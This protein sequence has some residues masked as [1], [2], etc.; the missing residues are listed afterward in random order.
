MLIGSVGYGL[1]AAAFGALALLMLTSWRGRLQG[2]LLV[3]AAGLSAAWATA[4][5]FTPTTATHWQLIGLLEI[6]RNTAWLVFLARLS[7]AGQGL[8]GT[9][10]QL[11]AHAPAAFVLIYGTAAIA[12]ARGVETV[13]IITQAL[14]FTGLV[15]AI[16]GLV[17]LEQAFRAMRA[18]PRKQILPLII[19]LGGILA[20]DLFLY[21]HGLL[22]RGLHG[23]LWAARGYANL[24]A[25]PFLLLA[26]RR[27]PDWSVDVFVSRHVAFYTTSL[28][29]IGAY[30]LVMS[31]AGY[32]LRIAGGEWG[33][34]F[35]VIFFFGS[36]VVLAWVLFS[37]TARAALRVFLAKHFYS[38]KY[39][40]REEWLNLTRRLTEGDPA[41]PLPTRGLRALAELVDAEGG[42]LWFN[43]TGGT[44]AQRDTESYQLGAT[45]G[46][47]AATV[48]TDLS[49]SDPL[50]EFLL[51][52][53]WTVNL[54]EA[55][56][57]PD[58][59]PG[60]EIPDWLGALNPRTLVVPLLNQDRLWGFAV[61][62][63]PRPLGRLSYEDID[64]FRIAGMQIAAVLA[65]AEADRLLTES[66]QFEA[67]NRFAAFIMHD[68]KNVIAQQS[69]VVQNA[70]RYRDDP[71]FIDDA[72]DTVANS[73]ERM[74]RLLEQL[75]RGRDATPIE[76]T[77]ISRLVADT[78]RHHTDRQPVPK[79]ESTDTALR[80]RINRERL[81][82]VLGHMI[83][84]AQDATPPHGHVRVEARL[85]EGWLVLAV[86]DDGAGMDEQFVRERLFKPFDSTKG[87]KGMGI[88][89][90]Q[91]R[92][93]VEAAGGEVRVR[94]APGEGTRFELR[95]PAALVEY[96]DCDEEPARSESGPPIKEVYQAGE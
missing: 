36:L 24:L 37:P 70:A 55:L 68:L 69:L 81:A 12:T 23:D 78:V 83:T 6:A 46:N 39:D 96:T 65:Q 40:Y 54:A 87:S 52:R 25:I 80:L 77:D 1:A 57:N 66:R 19:A 47:R 30:L 61:L 63:A 50:V 93:F 58:S 90:Y 74:Q 11:F 51:E 82:A 29:G 53:R 34:I 8:D 38:N 21:S 15:T 84:N 71:Q 76:R 32:G 4:A 16:G 43:A 14:I 73:V 44:G 85:E 35:Q 18:A 75:R 33:F 22:F 27:N 59:H 13:P 95:F 42:A 92:Q 5:A 91:A 9:R 7:P 86:E 48:P 79:A 94:S 20:Y 10:R 56:D 62:T 31:V 28:V 89:A 26:A 17:L 41:E 2:G 3:T 60:L 72:L 49:T 64:L 45:L 67:Y 88:G